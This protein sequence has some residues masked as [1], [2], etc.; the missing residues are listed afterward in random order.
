MR[1]LKLYI[2]A[3][4]DGFIASK[5]GGLE[6]LY[7]VPNPE[8][9]DYGYHEF[10]NSIDTVVMGMNTYNAIAS[11]GLDWPYA[12]KRCYVFTSKTGLELDGNVTFVSIDATEFV[13]ALKNQSGKDIWLLGGGLFSASMLRANLI[14]DIMVCVAPAIVGTGIKLFEE[15]DCEVGLSLVK[16]RV[17]DTGMVLLE[18][19]VR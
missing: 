10:Y 7:E 14:D 2:A 4:L 15:M 12:G 11:F 13:E 17:F 8:S 16:S 9:I 18:Y 1:S 6:W 3:S 19:R 5:K